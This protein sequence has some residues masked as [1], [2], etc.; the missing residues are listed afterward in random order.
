MK[1]KILITFLILYSSSLFSQI[2]ETPKEYDKIVFRYTKKSNYYFNKKGLYADTLLLKIDFPDKK[3]VMS[4]FPNDSTS[5]AGFIPIYKLDT[6][7]NIILRK[8]VSQNYSSTE[9]IFDVKKRKSTITKKFTDTSLIPKDL[10][11]FLTVKPIQF[12]PVPS[13]ITYKDNFQYLVENSIENTVDSYEK[14][15]IKWIEG[16]EKVGMF[17]YQLNNL[18]LTNL[19]Y[20]DPKLNKYIVP[21]T[22]FS[23]CEFGVTK[24]I[25]L[26]FTVELVSVSYK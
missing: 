11:D 20:V 14:N 2:E 23:N 9:V 19:I 12:K 1:I 6:K 16:N 15:T 26:L 25:S 22:L 3:F 21:T 18:I 13:F 8:I 10:F 24:I 4:K 7:D 17:D 5:T